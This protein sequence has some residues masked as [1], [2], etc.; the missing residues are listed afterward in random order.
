MAHGAHLSRNAFERF[1]DGSKTYFITSRCY[2]VGLEAATIRFRALRQSIAELN[3][4]T[5]KSVTE[6]CVYDDHLGL[7]ANWLPM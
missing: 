6:Y 5:L 3:L 4:H 7:D 1:S 2:D